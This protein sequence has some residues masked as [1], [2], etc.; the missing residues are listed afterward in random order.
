MVQLSISTLSSLRVVLNMILKGTRTMEL[1]EDATSEI[2]VTEFFGDLVTV[3]AVRDS[4]GSS[5][6]VMGTYLGPTVAICGADSYDSAWSIGLEWMC[7]N[8]PM[9][10]QPPD[11]EPANDDDWEGIDFVDGFGPRVTLDIIHT[12]TNFTD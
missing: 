11:T 1:V 12:F 8:R 5:V 6:L 9:M 7:E 10:I 4:E 2:Y 3:P